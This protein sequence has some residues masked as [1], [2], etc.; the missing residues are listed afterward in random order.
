MTILNP[1]LVPRP[2]PALCLLLAACAS[3][4]KPKTQI[5]AQDEPFDLDGSAGLGDP[6][7]PMAGN[8]GYDVEHYNIELVVDVEAGSIVGETSIFARATQ[9]LRSFHLDLF[10]FEVASVRVDGS[11]VEFE[12]EGSELIISPAKILP[13]DDVFRVSVAY[14]GVP[15]LVPDPSVAAMGLKGVGWIAKPK[16]I[17]VISEVQG[18]EGWFP[19][20]N[21]PSD[22]A[23]FTFLV[24]VPAPYVV[25]ANGLLVSGSE[26]DSGRA[27]RWEMRDPMATY[28]AT[29]NIGEFALRKEVGPGGIPLRLYYPKDATEA[30]LEPFA[31]TTELIDFFTE[32]FG[33]YPFDCFGGVLSAENFGGAL[34]T[35]TLPVY[36]R[37]TSESTVAHELAHMWFG[38]SVSPAQWKEIWLN[39]GFAVYSEWLWHEHLD[40]P[41]AL[42]ARAKH[43]YQTS[44]R[45]KFGSPHD[46]GIERVFGGAVYVRGAL[47]LDALR[48]EVGDEIFFEILQDWVREFGGGTADTQQFIELSEKVANRELDDLFDSW[49][50]AAG[51][52]NAALFEDE[53]AGDEG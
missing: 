44:K 49:L 29:I 19:C 18:A 39:E 33:P 21:H 52:P 48:R 24:Q 27:Y 7:Y 40:G 4:D 17:H 23:T 2:L 47:V 20:N 35:Q 51:V 46:P 22:K 13:A 12:R 31:R 26:D 36:S 16:G 14:S 45:A 8:G 5:E 50:Y 42:F 1:R 53:P 28:L 38:D 11:L 15:S 10:G 34:E 25:A 6:Y 32:C 30:E 3:T 41:E 37:R 9:D 43:A